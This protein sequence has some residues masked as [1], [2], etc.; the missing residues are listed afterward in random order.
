MLFHSV[1][2][3]PKLK[4]RCTGVV[5]FKNKRVSSK[6]KQWFHKTIRLYV[7]VKIIRIAS[8]NEILGMVFKITYTYRQQ[9]V[10]ISF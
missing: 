9:T 1:F 10:A 6:S 7:V 5:T 3:N 8:R 4:I 2:R